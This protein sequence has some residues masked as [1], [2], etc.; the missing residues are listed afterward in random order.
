MASPKVT[1]KVP[2]SLADALDIRW[3]RL[4]YQ[5]LSAYI[6]GLIRFDLMVQGE[7]P[8]SLPIAQSRPED[9]DKV[10]E[11]LLEITKTGIGIRGAFVAGLLKDISKGKFATPEEVGAELVRIMI[12]TAKERRENLDL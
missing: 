12:K 9:R 5:S 8:V 10:D 2:P 11:E 3:V 4:K 6:V 1:I 7:H